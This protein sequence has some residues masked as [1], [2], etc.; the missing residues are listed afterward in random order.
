MNAD[1]TDPANVAHAGDFDGFPDW[2]SLLNT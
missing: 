1:G 2:Q